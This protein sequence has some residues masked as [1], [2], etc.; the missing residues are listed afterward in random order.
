MG[1]SGSGKTEFI[2]RAAGR[3]W[4]YYMHPSCAVGQR[5]RLD[6][7]QVVLTDTPGFDDVEMSE[8]DVLNSVGDFFALNFKT[9]KKLSGAI[10]LHHIRD[11]RC[12]GLSARTIKVYQKFYG[13]S[14]LK[15][16]VI[17]TNFWRAV[18]EVIG[19]AREEELGTTTGSSNMPSRREPR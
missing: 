3:T 1:V 16:T 15:H 17:L 9:E 19:M 6:G 12:R 8:V 10:F 4:P 18:Q 13:E 2:N 11:N 5:F 7:R 14:A